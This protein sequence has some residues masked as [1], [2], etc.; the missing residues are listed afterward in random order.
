MCQPWAQYSKADSKT[1]FTSVGC[2]GLGKH[3]FCRNPNG[4]TT[5]W[6]YT[7]ER[8]ANNQNW[9]Y[10]QVGVA[11]DP[12]CLPNST[13]CY[14]YIDG[15]DYRGRQTKTKDG[16]ECIAWDSEFKVDGTTGVSYDSCTNVQEHNYCRNPNRF[17]APWCYTAAMTGDGGHGD[18]KDDVYRFE[19]CNLEDALNINVAEHTAACLLHTKR[20]QT[21]IDTVNA[22]VDEG[23]KEILED[24]AGQSITNYLQ[25]KWRNKQHLDSRCVLSPAPWVPSTLGPSTLGAGAKTRLES[26]IN[27]FEPY[28]I[29][30]SFLPGNQNKKAATPHQIN[31]QPQLLGAKDGVDYANA[32]AAGEFANRLMPTSAEVQKA[33]NE[34]QLAAPLLDMSASFPSLE[35]VGEQISIDHNR[36][37]MDVGNSF[38]HLQAVGGTL[39]I[40][41]N[42]RLTSMSGAFP[43]LH[44]VDQVVEI[45][46]NPVL[47]SM[48]RCFQAAVHFGGTFVINDNPAL[49]DVFEAFGQLVYV[50]DDVLFSRNGV[51]ALPPSFC[52]AL[53]R[54]GKPLILRSNPELV[55]LSGCFPSLRAVH[56]KLMVADNQ[57]LSLMY[58]SFVQLQ[59][60]GDVSAIKASSDYKPS[61]DDYNEYYGPQSYDATSQ[62]QTEIEDTLPNV[63]SG[64]I[65][66]DNKLDC[67]EGG[68]FGKLL[69]RK[70]AAV[71]ADLLTQ[72]RMH[73]SCTTT[74]TTTITA[75]TATATTITTATVTVTTTVATAIHITTPGNSME[76]ATTA[77]T[78]LLEAA[79]DSEGISKTIVIMIAVVISLAVFIGVAVILIVT[80]KADDSVI[81]K[82][83]AV[84]EGNLKKPL[85]RTASVTSMQ[86]SG[87]HFYPNPVRSKTPQPPTPSEIT[88]IVQAASRVEAVIRAASTSPSGQITNTDSTTTLNPVFES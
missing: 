87:G 61:D 59:L 80:Y 22:Y 70:A 57:K 7:S 12:L 26:S 27:K 83:L 4:A 30:D 48:R 5:P 75:T 72:S 11:N 2:A 18:K 68:T 6:C 35:Y 8:T 55:T 14:T 3:N 86:S 84:I 34:V 78:K 43:S 71:W 24:I 39:H 56:G 31:S 13:D 77:T 82:E 73:S 1:G 37:R 17:K 47:A 66:H 60:V 58:G 88:Q 85:S 29:Y 38:S 28:L 74:T 9:D 81:D 21:H 42:L 23:W 25:S 46:L 49:M 52:G 45:Q 51:N 53:E 15:S 19:E 50:H 54:V 76:N 67:V 40:M 20:V 64:L 33:V 32:L 63:D 41:T 62:L 36:V 65:I 44:H 69:T 10:C 16:V 79:S